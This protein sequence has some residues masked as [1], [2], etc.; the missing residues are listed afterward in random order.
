[1]AGLVPAIHVF[2]AAGFQD[3]DAR[4]IG[5]RKHAVLR[6]AMR[7][8]DEGNPV[9]KREIPELSHHVFPPTASGLARCELESR[10]LIDM[11]C[12]GEHAVRPQS[13][14]CVTFSSRK[15]HALVD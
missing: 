5:V 14:L 13:D 7:G 8:H 2:V 1:M 9:L 11:P 10:A 15:A 12:G 4:D 3:V 6:T